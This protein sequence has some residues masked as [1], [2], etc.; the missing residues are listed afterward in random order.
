MGCRDYTDDDHAIRA[1]EKLDLVTRLL[2]KMVTHFGV[3]PGD[4][5]LAAWK[6]KHDEMDRIR[7]AAEE[8]E[9]AKEAER[10]RQRNL[11][12]RAIGKLTLEELAALVAHQTGLDEFRAVA[13]AQRAARELDGRKREGDELTL[14][15]S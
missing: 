8:A 5:E 14:S 7:V 13:L 9:A 3:I 10:V 1:Q 2:C 12:E 4:E 6:K 15:K 11:V